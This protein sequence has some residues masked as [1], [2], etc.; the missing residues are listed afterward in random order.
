MKFIHV[1]KI[2]GTD[3][4]MINLK[5]TVGN[6]KLKFPGYCLISLVVHVPHVSRPFNLQTYLLTAQLT[7]QLSLPLNTPNCSTPLM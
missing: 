7:R 6:G 4:K 1:Y 3:R 2:H 5:K